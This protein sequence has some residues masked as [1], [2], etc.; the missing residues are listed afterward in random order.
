MLNGLKN[1]FPAILAI[2]LVVIV[3]I[4]LPTMMMDIFIGLN[5][6]F[7]IMILLIA[8]NTSKITELSLFPTLLKGDI[9]ILMAC[10]LGSK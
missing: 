5:L 3:I 2:A 6:I 1:S 4:P 7:A 9:M 8:L 10:G